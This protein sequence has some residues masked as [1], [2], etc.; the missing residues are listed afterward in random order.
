M[1]LNQN[2]Q[3]F[4]KSNAN[5]EG[6][7]SNAFADINNI[8]SLFTTQFSKWDIISYIAK[9][10]QQTYAFLSELISSAILLGLKKLLSFFVY[11]E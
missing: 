7:F 10:A 6:K 2:N 11:S 1:N 8:T 3:F 4:Y 5:F 9:N